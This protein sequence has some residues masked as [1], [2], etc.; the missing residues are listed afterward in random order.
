MP[1][2]QDRPDR[3]VELLWQ[4][5]SKRAGL[6]PQRPAAAGLDPAASQEPGP[7]QR[8]LVSLF[9]P[10]QPDP[11]SATASPA[12]AAKPQPGTSLRAPRRTPRAWRLLAPAVTLAVGLLLGLA[13]GLARA[14]GEPTSATATRSPATQPA[15]KPSPV[16]VVRPTA[17]S[18]CLETA[19]RGDQ[20]IH[21]LVT[22]RRSRAADLLVAYTV[23]SRQCRRDASP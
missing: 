9:E 5:L 13:L 22:N 16:V 3:E 8:R 1:K 11:A 15:P 2:Q 20:I 7:A 4:F 6:E 19:R 21:L 17:S 10:D 12:A 14:G 23:A 18:A